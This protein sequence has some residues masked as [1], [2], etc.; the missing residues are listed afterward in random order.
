MY[1]KQEQCGPIDL[2]AYAVRDC[3]VVQLPCTLGEHPEPLHAVEVEDSHMQQ[4]AV[5][6]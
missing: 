3:M 4:D 5:K 1:A 6:P 2:I